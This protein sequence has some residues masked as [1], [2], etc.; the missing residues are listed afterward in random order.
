MA[1]RAQCYLRHALVFIL[2]VKHKAFND[3]R[4]GKANDQS[5]GTRA[6]ARVAR[7]M[8]RTRPGASVLHF[9]MRSMQPLLPFT[10]V[11]KGR[12]ELARLK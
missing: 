9:A 6:A 3:F 8:P 10:T 5:C 12:M 4:V 2:H 11:Q 7:L 1:S